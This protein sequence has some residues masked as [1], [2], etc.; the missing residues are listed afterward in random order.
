MPWSQS[1]LGIDPDDSVRRKLEF[2]IAIGGDDFFFR[3]GEELFRRE[4]FLNDI[5]FVQLEQKGLSADR[6]ALDDDRFLL[7]GEVPA[8][9]PER[10]LLMKRKTFFPQRVAR[11]CGEYFR[12]RIFSGIGED[13]VKGKH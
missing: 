4:H 6:K 12:P 10:P 11:S 9:K 5:V 8:K 3:P 13:V 2:H 1:H 7:P